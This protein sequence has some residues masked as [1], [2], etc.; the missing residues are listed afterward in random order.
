MHHLRLQ[1]VEIGQ[2]VRDAADLAQ[3]ESMSKIDECFNETNQ[4]QAIDIRITLQ[5][6][7]QVAI[8]H[9]R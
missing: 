2:A 3:R 6:C 4:L 9:P 1:S 5:V 8:F 7:I